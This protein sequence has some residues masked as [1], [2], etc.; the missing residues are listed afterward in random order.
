MF[1]DIVLNKEIPHIKKGV[2][3]ELHFFDVYSSIA[4]KEGFEITTLYSPI[5]L[6]KA[7][8]F[9]GKFKIVKLFDYHHNPKKFQEFLDIYDSEY[10]DFVQNHTKSDHLAVLE[11]IGDATKQEV[12]NFHRRLI[13]SKSIFLV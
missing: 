1:Y 3:I 4:F 5:Y 8:P 13:H 11:K 7:K 9:M 12:L 10:L 6:P 2:D